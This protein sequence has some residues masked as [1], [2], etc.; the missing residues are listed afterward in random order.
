MCIVSMIH[1]E[2]GNLPTQKWQVFSHSLEAT[3][4]LEIFDELVRVAARLDAALGLP[5]CDDPRKVAW[6][7]ATREAVR[8]HKLA[9][10][11]RRLQK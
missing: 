10:L 11:E 1:E 8:K 5:D 2:Y 3:D 7:E 9:E 4:P 6:L